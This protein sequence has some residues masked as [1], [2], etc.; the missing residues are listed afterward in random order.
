MHIMYGVSGLKTIGSQIKT[1]I[2]QNLYINI[3]SGIK[4][5]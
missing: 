2:A 4:R 1:A 5:L 3:Y